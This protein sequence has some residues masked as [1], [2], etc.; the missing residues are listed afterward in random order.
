MRIP[1]IMW[2]DTDKTDETREKFQNA[3]EEGVFWHANQYVQYPKKTATR[4]IPANS[5]Q[6]KNLAKFYKGNYGE[7]TL[8]VSLAEFSVWRPFYL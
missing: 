8:P 6:P 5:R 4:F 3:H 1:V 7:S 2:L